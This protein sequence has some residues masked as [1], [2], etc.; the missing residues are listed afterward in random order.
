MKRYNIPALRWDF[1]SLAEDAKMYGDWFLVV[2]F[3]T[4]G[5]AMGAMVLGAILGTP[6]SLVMG[7][8]GYVIAG[9]VGAL[10]PICLM[11]ASHFHVLYGLGDEETRMAEEYYQLSKKD[12]KQLPYN[13][14][15]ILR[16]RDVTGD[17]K[18]RIVREAKGAI[19]AINTANAEKAN[20]IRRQIDIDPIL[21]LL[22]DARR[23]AQIEIDTYREYR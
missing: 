22:S 7:D 11:W 20:M 6:L 5:A 4:M 16:D 19:R 15:D 9:I 3:S 23:N 21:T 14:I 12:R 8:T 13:L 1:M 2:M 17:Q 18:T 10:T